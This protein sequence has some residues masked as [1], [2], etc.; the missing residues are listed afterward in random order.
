MVGPGYAMLQSNI[1]LFL[2]IMSSVGVLGGSL[3]TGHKKQ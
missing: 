2:I 3:L 1:S